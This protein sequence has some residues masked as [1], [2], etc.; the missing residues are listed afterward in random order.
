MPW[1]L[2]A[3]LAFLLLSACASHEAAADAPGAVEFEQLAPGVWMHTSYETVEGYGPVLSHGL[4]V[5]RG[6]HSV[7]VDTG[8]NDDQT[9]EIL[10]WVQTTLGKPVEAAVFTH[11]HSDKMGGVQA[12]RD[13]GIETYAN[14]LSNRLAP[15]VGLTPAEHSLELSDPGD[16]A[17]LDGLEVLYPGGGHTRDNI[18][19]YDPQ[20]RILFGGCLVR[21]AESDTLG[22]TNDADMA[23]WPQA[24]TNLLTAYPD[25]VMVV[26]SHGAPGGPELPGHTAALFETRAD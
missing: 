21:P 19:V 13:R 5:V 17:D 2:A 8:W 20:S 9:A 14:A 26:P 12:V 24:A 23:Y 1:R 18:T 3:G 16:T 7:L 10:D 6:D 11:A 22:N 25:A 4:I 15:S